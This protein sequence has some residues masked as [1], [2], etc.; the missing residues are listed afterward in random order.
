MNC[1]IFVVRCASRGSRRKLSALPIY[2]DDDANDLSELGL[3]LAA[4]SDR[5]GEIVRIVFFFHKPQTEPQSNEMLTNFSQF[6][7]QF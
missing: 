3:G 2:N 7:S 5:N 4:K 1:V 6:T